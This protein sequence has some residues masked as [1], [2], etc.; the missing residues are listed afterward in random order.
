MPPYSIGPSDLGSDNVP[1]LPR[2]ESC[3]FTG[4]YPMAKIEFE[5][6]ELPVRV[7]LQAFTPMIP[8]GRGRIGPAARCAA[9]SRHEPRR[10]QREGVDRLVD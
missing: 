2:L 6:A 4:E 7:S 9:L 5:D 10:V 3:T 8:I 1:G